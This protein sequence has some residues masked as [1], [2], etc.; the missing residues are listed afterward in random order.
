MENRS[1]SDKSSSSSSSSRWPVLTLVIT[2]FVGIISFLLVNN[3]NHLFNLDLDL[4]LDSWNKILS[5]LGQQI[6][7]AP[8]DP[9]DYLSRARQ[10]LRSTP[11]IDGHNDFPFLLRQQLK[12]RIYE[13]DFEAE[14]LASHTDLRKMREEGLM[15]GQFWSVYV[16]CPEELVPTSTPSDFVSYRRDGELVPGLNE[17]NVR[18]EI[19][20]IKLSLYKVAKYVRSEADL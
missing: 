6:D 10:I 11:L 15:G 13:H 7:E 4:G 9:T 17:P 14:R 18:D 19:S 12:N 2:V 5:L 8:I 1:G 16:P 20:T 3:N